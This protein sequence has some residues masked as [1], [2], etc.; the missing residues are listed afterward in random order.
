M[1]DFYMRNF[2]I[3]DE[4]FFQEF[5]P[6][7]MTEMN[8][9]ATLGHIINIALKIFPRSVIESILTAAVDGILDT[10]M[11]NCPQFWAMIPKERAKVIMPEP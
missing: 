1:G 8:G 2:N 3:E 5:L 4:F 10:L 9:Y 7:V 11:L 6:M